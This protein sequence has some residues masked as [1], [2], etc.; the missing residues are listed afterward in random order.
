MRGSLRYSKPKG[1]LIAPS[2]LAADFA[3]LGDE[4][5]RVEEGGCDMLHLDVMDGHFVPN[6][7]LGP[8]VVSSLRACTDLTFDAHLMI[9]QPDRY[10]EA[11][12]KA[13]A[14]HIT[15]HVESD[16]DTAA[17][18]RA[19]RELGCSAGLCLK[20]ATPASVIEPFLD[21]LSMVL[22]MTVEPG[23]GGQSFMA[24]MLP[25]IKTVRALSDQAARPFHVEVDGGIDAETAPLV[26]AA[27][28]DVLVAGTSVFRNPNGVAAAMAALRNK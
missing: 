12:A 7:S 17:T 11:F 10:V 19:I 25:K 15:I 26:A 21:L 1:L 14:D 27:G 2:I 24:D 23:F 20:P 9:S 16:G 4:A 3:C 28:A 8:P 22:V 5:R 6:I 18:L 13:G